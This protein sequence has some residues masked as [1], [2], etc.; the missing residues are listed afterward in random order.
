MILVESNLWPSIVIPLLP[1]RYRDAE[2]ILR[3]SQRT[4]RIGGECAGRVYQSIE[5]EPEFAG[6]RHAMVWQFG[7][8]K[9]SGTVRR[10]LAGS[11]PQN[12]EKIGRLG[13]FEHGLQ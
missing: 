11:V 2:P 6:L 10:R 13:I 1:G 7:I 9:A 3:R 5:I 4:R 8:Q 12:K